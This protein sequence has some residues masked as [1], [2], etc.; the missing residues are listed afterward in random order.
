[1]EN[2]VSIIAAIAAFAISAGMGKVLI[3]WLH[4]LKYGQPI[5]EIGPTWHSSKQG[6]PTMGG[7]MFIAG[8]VIAVC[9]CLPLFWGVSSK[10]VTTE[11]S[12]RIWA[13]FIMGVLYGLVGF[14]D[15]YIKIVRHHN[16]GLSF[17]QKIISQTGIA[18]A[19]LA[20][21]WISGDKGA[22]ATRIPFVE[23]PVNLGIW[24]Y[25]IGLIM[26][27]GFVNAVNLTDGVDGLC[28][29]VTFFA[30]ISFMLTA[31]LSSMLEISILAAAVAGGCLG[32]LVW[33][34]HPAKVFMGDTG[35]LFLGGM[36]CALAFG[37]K[38]P[39]LI[40][41][42]GIIYLC[43]AGSVIIQRYYFKL[44]HGK[45]IFKMSPIHHHFEMCGWSEVKIVVVFSCVTFAAGIIAA[46]LV[47]FGFPR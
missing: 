17:W 4:K 15:D 32:F 5:K 29:S 3:P 34:F 8:T 45:R 36:F 35:S 6:T 7:L 27:V 10:E 13:G 41:L 31:A 40:P 12:V 44:T 42:V 2:Y 24:F 30:A 19:Y 37:M 33:N 22:G 18:A 38:M 1:M 16:D 14:A 9:V 20:A 11:T 43:E 39:I 21:L 46:L 26:I 47:G 28:S 23:E 25:I